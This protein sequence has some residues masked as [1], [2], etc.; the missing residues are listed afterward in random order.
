[1]LCAHC[2]EYLMMRGR[3]DEIRVLYH[4]SRRKH[5]PDMEKC[6]LD[7]ALDQDFEKYREQINYG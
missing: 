3:Q 5:W 4:Q 6:T 2:W 1:M 7:A